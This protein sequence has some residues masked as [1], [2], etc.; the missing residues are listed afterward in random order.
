MHR[1]VP[2]RTLNINL[3]VGWYLSNLLKSVWNKTD[4]YIYAGPVS[5][6][7]RTGGRYDRRGRRVTI[8]KF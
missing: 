6:G 1:F 4:I 2:L 5:A 8:M 3:Q 7:V